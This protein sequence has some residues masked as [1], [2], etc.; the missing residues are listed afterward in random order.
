MMAEF[1][2]MGGYA[3]YIWPSYGLAAAVMV[4]LLLVTLR[5]LR[6][7]EATLKALEGLR[8]ARRRNSR[9]APAETAT[10]E[11]GAPDAGA[12][13]TDQQP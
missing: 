11:N 4:A 13:T 8:P 3:A 7:N 6:D 10:P 9:P 12:A 2:A 5:E 1:F